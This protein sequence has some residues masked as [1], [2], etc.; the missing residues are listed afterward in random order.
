MSCR[1]KYKAPEVS[2][3]QRLLA[4]FLNSWF[5]YKIGQ[6]ILKFLFPSYFKRIKLYEPA[7]DAKL[8]S[9][10]GKTEY[11]L[12]KD[13]VNKTPNGMPLIINIGSYN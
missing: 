3:L 10:D 13:Y 11:S 1:L 5:W 2:K 12:L 8:V 7:L 4:L 6:A 9:L